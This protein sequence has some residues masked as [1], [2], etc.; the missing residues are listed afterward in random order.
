MRDNRH[1]PP[2]GEAL[3]ALTAIVGERHALTAPEDV[4]PHLVEWRGLYRGRTAMVLRPGSTEEVSR[5]LAFAN[6]RRI[7]VVPQGGNTGLVGGQIPFE[8]GG[9]IVLSLSRLKRIRDIDP[10]GNTMVVEAGVTLE[11]AQKAA[12]GAGRL[13]ALSLASQGTCQVGGNLSTNAG[14]I[15]VLAY[16]NA[17]DQALGLEVVLADGRIWNGLRRLRKDN[18]GYDLRDLFIGAE[19]TLG[20]ITAATLKLAARPLATVTAIAGISSPQAAAALF[21]RARDASGPTLTAF[22][23]MPRIGIEFV[24]RHLP[25]ARDPLAG[26]HDWYVL[27]DLVSLSPSDDASQRMEDILA[28]AIEAGDVEDAAIASSKAQ[29]AALWS[30]RENLS[31]MQRHEGGSIKNDVSVPVAR[32]PELLT[33]ADAVVAAMMP[34]ARPVAFGHFGDG[35]IHYNISQPVGAD[36]AAFMARW[37]EVTE[38]VGEVVLGLD[39]SISAEHGI[40]RQKREKLAELKAGTE[41][42]LMRAIKS[43]LDPNGILNP[44]KVV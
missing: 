21:S 19:G 29:S 2:D 44:G 39:G 33:R 4:A 16:G 27:M 20:V 42:E 37:Q 5:I 25:G 3:V 18:T 23:I 11:A 1:Q 13:L 35:N 41:I 22:E 7:A 24:L 40:G 28:G 10:V 9:E 38:A 34:G 30:L 17:R 12:E 31:E 6:E 43:A 26:R 8:H 15:N 36:A 14:G 32:V